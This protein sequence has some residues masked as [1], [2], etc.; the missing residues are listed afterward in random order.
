MKEFQ[1]NSDQN[2][3]VSH[4]LRPVR[5]VRIIRIHIVE[6]HNW[7]SMRVEFVGCYYK[8]KGKLSSI[9]RKFNIAISNTLYKA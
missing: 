5:V 9:Y 8:D 4:P 1:G 6:Q 3:I 2:T 7:P